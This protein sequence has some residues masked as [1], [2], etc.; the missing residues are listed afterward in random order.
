MRA[1]NI[2]KQILGPIGAVLFVALV[3]GT[4]AGCGSWG[5]RDG[6]NGGA[7]GA[8]GAPVTAAETSQAPAPPEGKGARDN[9]V[10]RVT[11]TPGTVFA[12]TYGNLDKSHYEEGVLD[13]THDYKVD[14][15]KTGF[16]V[17]SA[18]FAKPRDDEGTLKAEI[19]VDGKVV[20]EG[21]T[22]IQFGSINVTWGFGG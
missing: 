19:V 11:G 16:D 17:V 20:A 21:D 9:V 3:L 15:R 1:K 10:V 7:A 22:S 13:K 4:F 18:S 2:T 6:G 5:A 8:R 12:G 14:V